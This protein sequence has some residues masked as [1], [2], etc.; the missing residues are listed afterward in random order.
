MP[1]SYISELKKVVYTKVSLLSIAYPKPAS[2]QAWRDVQNI[3][4]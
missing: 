3:R 2:I 4:I 1:Q